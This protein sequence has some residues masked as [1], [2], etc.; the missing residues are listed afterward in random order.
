MTID[1]NGNITLTNGSKVSSDGTYHELPP[2]AEWAEDGSAVT[3]IRKKAIGKDNLGYYA[4]DDNGNKRYY[5]E[6]TN[7]YT[8]LVGNNTNI[9]NEA[10][11]P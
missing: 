6:S 3:K 4:L 2:G 1:E 11:K 9:P 7:A 8:K 5:D 10:E